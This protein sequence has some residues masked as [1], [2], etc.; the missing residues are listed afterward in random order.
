[1]DN[2]GKAAQEKRSLLS[3]P[4]SFK[5]IIVVKDNIA[6]YHEENGF[7]HIG[8]FDFLLQPESLEF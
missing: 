6:M 7:L 8:L 3:L 5:K 4:D 2:E 1:M